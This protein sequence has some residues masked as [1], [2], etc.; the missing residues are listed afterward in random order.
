LDSRAEKWLVHLGV[1]SSVVVDVK[2]AGDYVHLMAEA[3]QSLRK[4]VLEVA[5]RSSEVFV[6]DGDPH[7]RSET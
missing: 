5:H 1:I 3:G 4:E 7:P 6:D 2:I